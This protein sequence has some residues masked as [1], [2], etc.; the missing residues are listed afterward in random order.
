MDLFKGLLLGWFI[1]EMPFFAV[2]SMIIVEFFKIKNE[3]I[4]FIIEKPFNCLKCGAFWATLLISGDIFVA[5]MAA[6][7]MY[8]YDSKFNTV[9]L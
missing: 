9:E 3:I 7:I 2:I 4:K 1:V 8:I 6:W 5:I